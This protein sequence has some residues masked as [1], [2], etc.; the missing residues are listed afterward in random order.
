MSFFYFFI[1]DNEEIVTGP[2]LGLAGNKDHTGGQAMGG[3]E[4]ESDQ[5][6]KNSKE[7]GTTRKSKS[8]ADELDVEMQ[9]YRCFAANNP[10]LGET[11]VGR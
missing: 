8:P 11:G 4:T 1:H 10:A 2:M 3:G 7:H 6:L 5:A 9:L